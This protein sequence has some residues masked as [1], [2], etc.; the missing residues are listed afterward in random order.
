MSMRELL[1]IVVAAVLVSLLVIIPLNPYFAAAT[2]PLSGERTIAVVP[3]EHSQ[4]LAAL[5]AN[6]A[7]SEVV[8]G[9]DMAN[10]AD[11]VV[12]WGMNSALEPQAINAIRRGAITVIAGVPDDFDTKVFPVPTMTISTQTMS[13]GM[14]AQ[15]GALVS[16]KVLGAAKE[17]AVAPGFLAYVLYDDGEVS[18]SSCFAAA[19]DSP[20]QR[21][22]VSEDAAQKVASILLEPASLDQGSTDQ[23]TKKRDSEYV[24]SINDQGDQLYSLREVYQLNYWDEVANKDYWRVDSTIDH[25]L[26]SYQ[27]NL[28]GCGPYVDQ[29]GL[30]VDCS[31]GAS[32]YKYDPKTTAADV[33]ASVNIG[34]DITTGGAGL[35]V[36][37]SWSWSNPGVTY[38][39][40]ADYVNRKMNW[41]EQFRGPI[42]TWYPISWT[43]PTDAAHYSYWV[44]PSVVMRTTKGS[45]FFID[46]WTSSWRIYDDTLVP[47]FPFSYVYRSITTYTLSENWL[48]FSSMFGSGGGG[49]PFLQVWNGSDYVDEGLLNIHNADGVDVI[50]E[51]T[52]ATVPESVNGRYALRLTEHPKTISDIDQVQLRA[53]LED[54][55]M[56]ELPLKAAWHSEDGNVRNLLSKSDDRRAEEKGADHNGGTSQ[57]IDLEFAA[58][59][60]QAKAVAFIFTI[61][62]YNMICKTCV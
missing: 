40:S 27:E 11:V 15:T 58:L 38:Q 4:E 16:S 39:A 44:V 48:S 22:Y 25:Y 62:G 57:S 5:I 51:H 3:G 54:G 42:Y 59:G 55:T 1:R 47:S 49:C 19:T 23:W 12:F 17:E 6:Y 31:A 29:R 28:F 32:I 36:G 14:D 2:A 26:P 43:G 52:L 21:E 45:N 34:F 20:T 61:E 50:Y 8:S 10:S 24:Y 60:P 13:V 30:S 41:V 35:H 56:Q 33:G 9:F 37:Y 18:H 7:D 46:H 53:I